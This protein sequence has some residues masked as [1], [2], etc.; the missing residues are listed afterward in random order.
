MA[1]DRA[2]LTKTVNERLD[3]Y[4]RRRLKSTKVGYQ[5]YFD[6]YTNYTVRKKNGKGVKT[7]RIYTADYYTH[8]C[9]DK[10]WLRYKITYAVLS[11]AAVAL[12]L[13]AALSPS[14]SSVWAPVAVPGSLSAA[15]MLMYVA[16]MICYLASPRLMTSWTQSNYRKFVLAFSL[17]SW[18]G[19]AITA[20][21]DLIYMIFVTDTGKLTELL[22]TAEYALSAAAVWYVW[23]TEKDMDYCTVPNE[24]E[25]PDFE[26]LVLISK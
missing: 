21:F 19:L 25:I 22:S 2:K 16:Y 12:F 11:V 10:T 23:K 13:I 3:S 15:A 17:I 26:D 7:I 9:D 20:L 24:A 14:T 1:I 6:G 18:A 8:D 4:P 5:K